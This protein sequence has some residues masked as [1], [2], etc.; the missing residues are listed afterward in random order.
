MHWE[1]EGDQ[2]NVLIFT[3]YISNGLI[4]LILVKT[5]DMKN[6]RSARQIKKWKETKIIVNDTL[7]NS[8]LWW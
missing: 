1:D 7:W 5:L 6:I 4:I 3:H 8:L 2:N